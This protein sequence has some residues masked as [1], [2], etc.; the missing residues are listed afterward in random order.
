MSGRGRSGEHPSHSTSSSKL[1]LRRVTASLSRAPVFR[2]DFD[3][4]SPEL[5]RPR[6]DDSLAAL[7]LAGNGDANL[8]SSGRSEFS[9]PLESCLPPAELSLLQL[10]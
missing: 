3:D 4:T 1:T 6:P 7:E 5:S 10:A 9:S 8:P 2:D